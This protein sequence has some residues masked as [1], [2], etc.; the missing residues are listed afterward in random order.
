MK[1]SLSKEMTPAVERTVNEQIASVAVAGG[2]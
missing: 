1:F 2:G